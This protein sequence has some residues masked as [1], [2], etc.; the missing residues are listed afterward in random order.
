MT[1]RS[2]RYDVL[3]AAP[4]GRVCR[5]PDGRW[6]GSAAGGDADRVQEGVDVVALLHE[7]HC[8]SSSGSLAQTAPHAHRDHGTSRPPAQIR[9]SARTSD[10]VGKQHVDQ[11]DRRTVVAGHGQGGS[12]VAGLGHQL[13]VRLQRDRVRDRL[14]H[15][16]VI[17]DHEH[18]DRS[19]RSGCVAGCRSSGRESAAGQGAQPGSRGQDTEGV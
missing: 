6:R 12:S 5:P 9:R 19:G 14:T 11:R 17:V 3:A 10:V 16:S 2:R 7:V 18:A 4:R 1:S 8:P 15:P 13:H